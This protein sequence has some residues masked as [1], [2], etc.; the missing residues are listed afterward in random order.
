MI[1]VDTSVWVDHLRQGV[2]PLRDLLEDGEV[3]VH[4][5]VIAELACGYLQQRQGFLERLQHMPR[6][7]VVTND[8]LLAFIEAHSLMGTGLN[9]VDMHLLASSQ[10][11]AGVSLWSHDLRLHKLGQPSWRH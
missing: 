1:L 7:P 8:E 3:L 4:E 2:S 6:A 11:Q 9:F 5:Y 10:L